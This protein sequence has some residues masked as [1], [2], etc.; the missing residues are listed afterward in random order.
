MSAPLMPSVDPYQRMFGRLYAPDPKDAA[1]PLERA[2]RT[3]SRT[4]LKRRT[5]A[6][7]RAKTLNQRATSYCTKFGL[8]HCLGAS[9]LRYRDNPMALLDVPLDG[10]PEAYAWAQAH[11]E[12]PGGEPDYYGTSVRA[13]LDYA[14]ARG[15]ITMYV[16]ARDVA[17]AKDY[18]SRVGSAPLEAGFDWFT[19]MS[20]PTLRN[21]IWVAE[22]NGALEGGH[23]FCVLWFDK[24][25]GMWKCQN[26]WGSE[27]GADGVFYI[28]DDA[29]QYLA[30]Q[31][32]GE[33]AS[34]TEAP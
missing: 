14:R 13:M 20:N 26:S 28:P 21:G 5:Q 6:P 29:F 3:M 31:A 25:R 1:F 30:F 16:W 2:M 4:E 8:A 9:P 18:V 19:G 24:K 27:F 23:A 12:W 15:L 17:E 34:F 7:A 10:S 22:P 11:D 32:N 33:L